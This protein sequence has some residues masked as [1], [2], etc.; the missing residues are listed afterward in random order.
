MTSISTFII[1]WT[2]KAS[3]DQRAGRAGRTCPGHCY[4]LYSSSVFNDQFK[5]YT[6]PEILIKPFDD[7]LLHMKAIGIINVINFP[8][9]TL[10]N[11]ES[12]ISAEKLLINLDALEEDICIGKKEK[13]TKVTT[14]GK[15]MSY[16]PINP[17]YSKILC[18]SNQYD[19]IPHLLVIISSL[20]VQEI[21]LP[22][23]GEVIE[24]RKRE[25]FFINPYC[26]ILGDLMIF[27]CVFG[28]AQHED[29]SRNFCKHFGIRYSAIVEI[30]KLRHQLFNEIQRILKDETITNELIIPDQNQIQMLSKLFLCGFSDH[31]AKRV[32]VTCVAE[33]DESGNV[34]KIERTIRNCYQT[35]ELDDYVFISPNSV[36]H[37]ETYEYVVYHEIFETSKLYMRNNVPIKAEWLPIYASKHCKFSNPLEEPPPRYDPKADKVKCHRTST[38]GRNNW[39]L[40]AV[41]VD[42]PD[43]I[44]KFFYFAYFLFEG[45]ILK[46]FENQK[47]FMSI[48]ANIFL[49]SWGRIQAKVENVIKCF[50]NNN[51]CTKQSLL[52]KWKNDKKCNK[53]FLNLI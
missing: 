47:K 46:W 16:F 3:A 28:A 17:R 52:D 4:R 35:N 40:P 25:A 31:V 5:Q 9:P 6:D 45:H 20:S 2:S 21:F 23:Q 14:M 32:P 24:K 8:F 43:C 29:L 30:D 53:N 22:E 19:I 41:E 33:A 10:P 18:I 49:R 27:L 42:Y 7:L 48:P 12:L 11:I 44:E 15:L 37:N 50:T 36:L 38:F 39:P 34:R 1:D 51:I 13:R 26:K